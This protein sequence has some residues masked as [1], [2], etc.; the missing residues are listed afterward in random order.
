MKN[1]L[2]QTASLLGL[3]LFSAQ[4][5]AQAPPLGSAADFV[6]FT[7]VGAVGNTGIS[8]ITGNVGTNSGAITGF[9]NVNGVMNSGNG[10]TAQ[11]AADL[12]IAYNLLNTAVPNFF[13]APL[14]GNGQILGEGVYSIVAPATLNNEL[15]LDAQNDPNAVFIFQING[16]LSTTA[17]SSVTLIN[18]AQACNVFWKIEGLVDMAVGTTMRGTLIAN[19]GAIN[20]NTDVV[21]EGR[22]L[23][24][25][26]AVNI[27]SAQASTP[28]GCSSPV[29]MGPGAPNLVSAGCYAVFTSNGPAAN[30]GVTHVVGDV[31]T[32][33]GLTTGFNPLFVSGEVHP[34]PD[35]STASA[36]VDLLNAYNYL[37]LLPYDIELLFPAQFGN[38]LVLTPHTYL[39]NAATSFTGNLYLNAG[40]EQDAVFVI[41][42]SGALTT[43]TFANVILT[44]G[45]Q[46][47]NVFW[48]VNG[49]VAINDN[50]T[51]VGTIIAH[52]GA[53]E[54]NTGV[55]LQGRAFSTTGAMSIAA[56]NITI[57]PGHICAP[58]VSAQLKDVFCGATNISMHQILRSINVGAPQY[59]FRITGA[60]NGAPGWNNNQFIHTA[61]VGKRHFRFQFI[62]G[63]VWGE[64]YSVEVAVGDGGGNF[65]SYGMACNVTLEAQT[66]TQITSATCGAT[67]TMG[68]FVH[69]DWAPGA[70]GYRF[71]IQ[72]ANNGGVGWSGNTFIYETTAPVRSFKFN[73]HIH[74]SLFNE[75]YAIDVAVLSAD[76]SWLPYGAPC[77][78]TLAAPTTQIQASQCG[79]TNVLP[80]TSIL[81]NSVA[82][83]SGYRFK[84]VGANFTNWANNTFIVDRPNRTFWLHQVTGSLVGETYQV[85]VAVMDANGNYGAYGSMCTLTR[86][87]VIGLPINENDLFV[88]SKSLD[89]MTFEATGSHNPFTTEFGLQ[90]LNANDSETINV[91]IYD[92]SGKLIERN[93]VNPM[94]I[95]VAK[96]GSN[97]ASG[98]YMVEVRQ[99]SNQAVIRQVKN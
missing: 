10:T 63:S 37:N 48:R 70:L 16:T 6:L 14:L 3:L 53:V 11:C 42:I 55:N 79:I 80:E 97:L 47:K 28:I 85:S 76:G 86:F 73:N 89:G 66:T 19:N 90:V 74:G 44:N 17:H 68:D 41:Q 69:A 22:A 32:N 12:L 56:A 59:R 92:M 15:T 75:T 46:P 65:G 39:L 84:F 24:T 2:I 60:N 23:S 67:V 64:T 31:G 62:P 40:G 26:G 30:T 8:H 57:P 43:G 35:G 36:A 96:F 13:P 98:M 20:I 61:P 83:A 93:A 51:F 54:V 82:G 88:S 27:A 29:L 49:A 77:N 87:G 18:G 58:F 1:K 38:D 94:D 4:S 9:G 34:I 99:G 52:N 7:T 25:V 95:E 91:T 71:R 45:A 81:A 5:L 21:L 78:V 50:S 72:G 33:V